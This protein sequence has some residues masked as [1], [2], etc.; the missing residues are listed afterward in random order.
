MGVEDK[1]SASSTDRLSGADAPQSLASSFASV[2]ALEAAFARLTHPRAASDAF[3]YSFGASLAAALEQLADYLQQVVTPFGSPSYPAYL[4]ITN[5][6]ST[7][8]IHME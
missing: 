3:A 6:L 4:D 1:I 5:F 8:V 7:G 2:R